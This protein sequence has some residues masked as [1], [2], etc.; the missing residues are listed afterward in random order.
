MKPTIFVNGGCVQNVIG[1]DAY[2]AYNLVDFDSLESGACPNCGK[3]FDPEELVLYC[4]DCKYDWDA[5]ELNDEELARHLDKS[6]G[7]MVCIMMYSFDELPTDEAKAKAIEKHRHWNV[8]DHDWWEWDTDD[9]L[10]VLKTE[11]GIGAET[12]W[13]NIDRGPYAYLEKPHIDDLPKFLKTLGF[14]L[15]R[16]APRM[17][18]SGLA[19]IEIS[20]S[21][22]SKSNSIEVF[23][24][25]DDWEKYEE[26]YHDIERAFKWWIGEKLFDFRKTLSAEYE[27]QTSDKGV[28][29]ALI[30]NDH[31]K[32]LEDGTKVPYIIS[33][34]VNS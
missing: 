16:K 17:L 20:G 26:D 9:F 13:F 32:F 10:E 18:L 11:H 22:G 24:Y 4:P 29:E 28:A 7:E 5:A 14:D 25:A 27:Y 34:T 21:Y 2:N 8:E 31:I 19:E 3:E 30:C 15:R 33:D 1:L 6:P 12:I 23:S